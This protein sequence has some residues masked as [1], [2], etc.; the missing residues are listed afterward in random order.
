[1]S[2]ELQK[3][4]RSSNLTVR[5]RQTSNV[6]EPSASSQMAPSVAWSVFY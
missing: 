6:K 3:T 4:K 1:M 5:K 2:V